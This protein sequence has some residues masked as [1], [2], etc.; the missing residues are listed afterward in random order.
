MKFRIREQGV[1]AQTSGIQ[2][3]FYLDPSISY[4][5]T[6]FTYNVALFYELFCILCS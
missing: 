4:M 2:T 3:I 1:I 5:D 6:V